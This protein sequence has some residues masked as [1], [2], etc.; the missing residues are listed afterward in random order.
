MDLSSLMSR[1][2]F[3]KSESVTVRVKTLKVVEFRSELEQSKNKLLI[4]VREPDEYKSGFIPGAKNI[5]LS[6]LEKRLGEIPKDRDVLLY[7]RSGMRSKSAASILSK[8][9]YTRLA[10][11]QG[12]VSS[13]DGKLSRR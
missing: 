3:G 9:R 11:L 6:Q 1:L 2:G 12:G 7:C 10:H 4:D 13:W 5:P 8:Q